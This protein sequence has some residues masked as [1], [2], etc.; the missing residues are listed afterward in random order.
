MPSI[1][2]PLDHNVREIRLLKIKPAPFDAKIEGQLFHTSLDDPCPYEALSYRWGAMEFSEPITLDGQPF[3]ITKSLDEALR[4][5]RDE[6]EART[7]WVDAVCINQAD[8]SERN[9]QVS[10]MRD[11]YA[12][13]TADLAWLGPSAGPQEQDA[14]EECSGD[15]ELS[16]GLELMRKIAQRDEGTLAALRYCESK[17]FGWRD[18]LVLEYD[19]QR[20]LDAAFLHAP[21]WKRIWVMQ[22]LS[23]APRVV[24]VAGKTTLDWDL[25]ANFLGDT[26][27]SDAF[28][29]VWSH[30]SLHPA[31]FYTFE[32]AQIIQ[33]QRNIVR[34]VA[35]GNHKSSLMDVLAGFKFASSTDPRDKIFGLLGLVS[36]DHAIK[37]DYNKTA[38]QI[39]TDTCRFFIDSSGNL[40]IICQSP[41][42]PEESSVPETR[43]TDKLPSWVVD[44]SSDT[45]SGIKDHFSALLFAQRGIFSAGT[46]TCETPC[47]V[48]ESLDALRVKAIVLDTIGE[49]LQ[50]DYLSE[51]H[52]SW[53]HRRWSGPEAPD[54][55][56]TATIK[57][58]MKLSLRSSSKGD[59]RDASW[60]SSSYEAT[61]EPLFQAFWRTL[62]MDCKAYPIKRLDGDDIAAYGALF[63]Q[64]LL[65]DPSP[66]SSD[67]DSAEVLEGLGIKS[68]LGRMLDRNSP[69]WS[70]LASARGLFCMVKKGAREG[71]VVAVLDGGKVPVI[72]R[73]LEGDSSSFSVVT[74]AYVHGYMDG[75]AMAA[76]EKGKLERR[77]I[78][79]V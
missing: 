39:F 27:Y 29:L 30:N 6:S 70:F 57:E 49:I 37:V 68:E 59:E 62:V 32:I 58:W 66:G 33:E 73:P 61:G 18:E 47:Q 5:L 19:K 44:F 45:H 43:Q 11:I 10:L 76:V 12:R 69:R 22:E 48:S 50:P 46:K 60:K 26:P 54:S 16:L 4:H 53:W 40:D 8:T 17:P 74:T 14:R 3:H 35:A 9:H 72:L 20:L 28:H 36:E 65:S 71:D 56:E 15:P 38:A 52:K 1:Y 42:Q 63:A 64:L 67:G 2:R 31:V 75:E 13:C 23:C 21:L 24:L 34:D 7:L 51:T 55:I 41:W 25:V 77:D 78:F 79:L